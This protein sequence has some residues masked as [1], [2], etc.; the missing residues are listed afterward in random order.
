VP[1]EFIGRARALRRRVAAEHEAFEAAAERMV[2]P[3]RPRPG[4][5]PVPRHVLMRALLTA[6]RRRLRAGRLALS[7]EFAGGGLTLTDLRLAPAGVSSDAWA[8]DEPAVAIVAYRLCIRPPAFSE[9]GALVCTVGLHALARRYERGADR[10]D[11]AVIAD[12]GCLARLLPDA[13]RRGGE[14]DISAPGGRWIGAVDGASPI[15]RTFVD[16]Q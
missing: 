1:V 15:V 9:T 16:G 11:D 5:R 7:A 12:L 8:E 13:L 10:T 2:A 6:F 3:L 4:F 14:F